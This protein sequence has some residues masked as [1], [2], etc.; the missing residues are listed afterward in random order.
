MRRSAGG[1][2]RRS[3]LRG[4]GALGLAAAS[5]ALRRAW[6]QD[7]MAGGAQARR[8]CPA[9]TS[10]LSLGHAMLSIDGRP[11]H[12]VTV[13]GASPGPLL[14]LKEG[15]TVRLSVANTLDEESSIH[16][17]GLMVPPPMDGVPG[18]SFPGIRPARPS[19]TRSRSASRGTYWYHSHSGL[20]EQ[21]GLYGPII[22]D[23]PGPTRSSPIASMSWCCPTTASSTRTRSSCA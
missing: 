10:G 3:L 1:L 2:E 13:N 15:Q 23:P 11:G 5:G 9:T 18:V 19:A 16:W 7:A 4:A 17:H 12:A 8:R 21:E 20:Q 22:I 6:A 14:R